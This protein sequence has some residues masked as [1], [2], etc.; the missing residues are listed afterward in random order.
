[1]GFIQKKKL[2]YIDGLIKL[3]NTKKEE[4]MS[5]AQYSKANGEKMYSRLARSIAPE[6]YGYED[7]KKALLTLMVGG[8]RCKKTDGIKIRGD[9]HICL[10]GDPGV[11]KSQL[12]KFICKVAPRV[13]YTN[14]RGSSNA[15]LTASVMKDKITS[16][17]VLE[18]GSLVLADMGIC[19]IDEFDKMDET[20][21][22]A[23]HEAMEQQTVSIAKAGIT[24]TFNARTSILAAANPVYGR[25]NINLTPAENI[26]FPV[27]L[28][29]RFD[30]L[31]V[32]L[33][34]PDKEADRKLAA[35]VVFVH[36]N[37]K[38]PKSHSLSKNITK[39]EKSSKS[40]NIKN[41]K[42]FSILEKNK[43]KK[44]IQDRER[45]NV[46]LSPEMIRSYIAIAKEYYPYIPVDLTE[47]LAT[48]Y[49]EIRINE[50]QD[51]MSTSY[52]TPRTLLSII[53][54]SQAIA[55]LELRN[56]VTSQ[57]IEESLRLIHLSKASLNDEYTDKSNQKR[58]YKI[59]NI[60]QKIRDMIRE[61]K[62]SKKNLCHDKNSFITRK[63]IFDK[64]SLEYTDEMIN[65]ALELCRTI[66]IKGL[67]L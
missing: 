4:L 3:S 27:S 31:W 57:D 58:E 12:L 60:I 30:L 46:P 43:N 10:M 62:K 28:L 35:H 17:I 48:I 1:M 54:I 39:I 33:D 61:L 2:S 32:I 66:K 56:V 44:I 63:D 36:R 16:E 22:T 59:R 7:V 29:T 41:E 67:N 14:G 21:R 40:T 24:T 37:K 52:T 53:R 45:I 8:V 49:A 19:C 64:L 34:R 26:D 47:W 15:G 38:A 18:G 42:Q 13:V 25:Y 51:D 5:I 9:I 23:I 50:Y 55:R 20:D 6:I 65:S 11:A